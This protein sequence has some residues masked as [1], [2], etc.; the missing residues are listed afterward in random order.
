M[1]TVAEKVAEKMGK[2]DGMPTDVFF[3]NNKTA[4]R[5][6]SNV[7]AKAEVAKNK[8]M[9][10]AAKGGYVGYVDGGDVTTPVEPIEPEEPDDVPTKTP[11]ELAKE[12]QDRIDAQNKT[13]GEKSYT[14]VADPTSLVTKTPVQKLNA[15]LKTLD[16]TKVLEMLTEEREVGKRVA[17]L[18][19]LHQRYTTLRAARE[20]IEILQEAR[21]P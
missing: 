15:E 3:K 5:V 6:L 1:T 20:R 8:T 10:M 11:E 19:R 9:M 14:A 4:A 16:E 17:V 21:R 13:I 18:E 2:P 12:E 7:M